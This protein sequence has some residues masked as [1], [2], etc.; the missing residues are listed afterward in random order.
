M[1]LGTVALT[2]LA[3]AMGILL[4]ACG[5]GGA[6]P[7]DS[8]LPAREPA[9]AIEGPPGTVE[10]NQPPLSPS[11]SATERSTA[12]A[13]PTP[14]PSPTP[15]PLP[16]GTPLPRIDGPQLLRNASARLAGTY[17]LVY[18]IKASDAE[19]GE[20]D[21][22]LTVAARPPQ[23]R[24]GISGKIGG[25]QGSFIVI[26]DGAGGFMCIEGQGDSTCLRTQ[27]NGQ[28]PI[29]VPSVLSFEKILQRIA[30]APGGNVREV[31]GQTVAGRPGRCFEVRTSDGS[32]LVCVQESEALVLLVDGQFGG[33]RV[34]LQLREYTTS[35][36]DAEFAP[37]FPV[38][39]LP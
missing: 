2:G 20:I 13:T 23:Q 9:G 31:A 24:A 5:G 7:G 18:Q 21:G 32:G 3:T 36:G 12:P 10:A 28:S 15:S 6:G 22:T 1:G 30:Q 14:T 35:P 27:S 38:V 17:R 8:W 11:A 25:D 33:T 34:N 19:A 4:A 37:P 29:P 16:A 39:E 26:Q